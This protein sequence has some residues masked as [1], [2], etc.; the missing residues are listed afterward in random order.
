MGFEAFNSILMKHRCSP[1]NLHP[2]RV[3]IPANNR[4]VLRLHHVRTETRATR[5]DVTH[6]RDIFHAPR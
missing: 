4:G 6:D 5:G 3:Q 1:P 2:D